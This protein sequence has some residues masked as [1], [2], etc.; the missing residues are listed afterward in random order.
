MKIKFFKLIL[1]VAVVAFGLAGA[2]HTNAMDKKATKLVNK[3]GYTHIDGENC[4]LTNVMCRTEIG[5]PCK[6]GSNQLYDFVSTTSCPNPLNKI[7]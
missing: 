7:P 3:W 5:P 2:M 4:V 6:Q 1:P